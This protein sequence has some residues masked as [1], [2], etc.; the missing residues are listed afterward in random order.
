ME[1]VNES[2]LEAA[3]IVGKINPPRFSLTAIVKGTFLLRPGETAMLAEEQLPLTGDKFEA[4]DLSKPLRYPADFA[5]FKPRADALLVG[6]CHVPEGNPLTV[7]RVTFQIGPRAKSLVVYGDREW[8]AGG[9]ATDPAP[10][11]VLPLSW[12]RAYGGAAFERNPLGRGFELSVGGAA[13]DGHPLPNVEFS[14]RP[15]RLPAD[16]VEPAGFNPI[17]DS[18]PQRAQKFGTFDDRY[19]KERWP[20]APGNIDWGF[21]NAAP[22][23]QQIEGYLRGDEELYMENLH[24]TT[25]H[26]RSRL[27]GLRVRCFLN[28]L[29]RDRYGLRE[30]PM[31]LDTSWVDMDAETLVLVWRGVVD[32]RSRNLIGIEHFFVLTEPLERLPNNVKQCAQLLE[33]ALARREMQDDELEAEEPEELVDAD[34]AQDQDE[35]PAAE[36]ASA[37]PA[38]DGATLSSDAASDADPSSDAEASLP[39]ATP[40][41]DE[42]LNATPLDEAPL[43]AER[44]RELAAQHASFAGCDLSGLALAGV[45]LRGLDLR[46][47]I[48]VNATLVGANLSGADL[49]GSVLTGANLR[50]ATC[51][52]TIFAAADLTETWWTGADLSAAVLVGANLDEGEAAAGPDGWRESGGSRLRRGGP[53]G[54]DV[55]RREPQ[56]G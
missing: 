17:P 9:L 44:V 27:P 22:V 54:R 45:D 23:D 2:G 31:R 51:T 49:T 30:I 43:T 14:G 34:E 39:D 5:P 3:W 21:F 40:P 37:S 55:S 1:F 20:W 29:V 15:L 18:W 24:P 26:Y 12:E 38:G 7:A 42:P 46:E 35:E 8:T 41:D 13:I 53:I 56:R 52:E 6:T 16:R 19:L 50:G 4:D 47:A 25:Q 10:F 11:T 33:G 36:S 32:L 48:L 28:E